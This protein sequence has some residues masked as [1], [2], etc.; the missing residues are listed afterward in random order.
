[1]VDWLRCSYSCCK[2]FTRIHY[3]E[4]TSKRRNTIRVANDIKVEVIREPPLEINNDFV[5]HLHDVLYVSSIRRNSISFW[6]LEND[7]F[8]HHFGNKWCLIKFYNN[9]VGLA[10]WQD[11]LYLL[12]LNQSVNVVSTKNVSLSMNKNK[13]KRIDDVYLKLW[14]YHLDHISRGV[15]EHMWII[16]IHL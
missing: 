15:I 6:Y 11:K 4:N 7:G 8:D 3:E 16:M 12:S 14:H 5:L 2:L 10:F 13:H 9:V 1:L